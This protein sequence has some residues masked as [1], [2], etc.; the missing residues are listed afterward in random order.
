MKEDSKLKLTVTLLCCAVTIL[1]FLL[2]AYLFF[3][4]HTEIYS[5]RHAHTYDTLTEYETNTIEDPSAPAGIRKEYRIILKNFDSSESCLCFYLV[6]H[7]ADVYIDNELVY[8]LSFSEN[9]KI[10]NTTSSNWVTVPIHEND[11]GK[12]LKIVLTPLFEIVSRFTPKFLIGSH[13]SIVVSQF[14]KD[15]PQLFIALLCIIW[16]IFIAF[17]QVFFTLHTKTK[18]WDLLYLA[19][20]A[21]LLGI[22]RMA[23]TKTS[24]ILFSG[25]PLALGYISIGSLFLCSIFLQLYVSTFFTPKR[26]KQFLAITASSCFIVYF[27]WLLQILNVSEFEQMISVSHLL[28]IVTICGIL[29]FSLLSRKEVKQNPFFL[30]LIVGLAADVL[31]YYL[32][33]SSTYVVFTGL[34]FIFYSM[35]VFVTNLLDATKKAQLDSP[36]GLLNKSRWN[37]LMKN[38]HLSEETIAITMIDLN[39]LKHINDTYGHEVGDKMIYEF[40]KILKSAFPS[41]S[42]I[43]RWGGDEF[44]VMTEHKYAEANEQYIEKLHAAISNYNSQA[45]QYA[46]SYAVGCCLSTEYP[47]ADC[48]ELLKIADERMYTNKIQSKME[49]N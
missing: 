9:N 11:S 23:A 34:A 2:Y 16:G 12:E 26:R 28:I 48:E 39:N 25:N 13:Y 37:E 10:S 4:E 1:F 17:T 49:Q 36:T 24:P 18:T 40:S 8:S 19:S 33:G 35:I 21:F 44:V 41:N 29:F 27:V 42:V 31:S 38:I 45:Q 6:H 20:F 46:L 14:K 7:A 47:K 15:I 5:S 22:W 3:F 32:L 43:C 30:I